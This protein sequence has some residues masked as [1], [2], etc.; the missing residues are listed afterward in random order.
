M[1]AEDLPRVRIAVI[2]NADVGKSALTVR[3]LTGRFIG[4]YRSNTDLLYNKTIS[5]DAGL[6]E[7]EIVDVYAGNEEDFPMEQVLWA[8]ACMVV[9]NITERKSFGYASK[10]LGEIKALQN[11]PSAYLIGNKAD[12]DHLREIPEKEGAALAAAH[13]IGFCEVSVAEFTPILSKAFE[14]LII[15]SRARPQKQVRKFSVSKMLGTLIG[16]SGY[17]SNRNL[18][19][20]Q[21]T[22]IPCH[23]GELH[24]TRVL[25][26]RQGFMATSSL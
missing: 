7:V 1:R 25:K 4:E 2:G 18:A 21:G 16:S 10:C 15:D 5:L 26:R 20:N 13:S 22:V 14:K 9:Y 19:I 6:T 3:Y 17:G 11:G 8:D 12:L 24:K 23:K